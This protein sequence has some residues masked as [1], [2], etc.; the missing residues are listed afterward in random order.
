MRVGEFSKKN[1]RGI[2]F[3]GKYPTVGEA[4][5]DFQGVVTIS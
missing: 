2:S 3:L 1:H 4:R 5:D